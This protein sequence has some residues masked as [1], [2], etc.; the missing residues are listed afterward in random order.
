[1]TAYALPMTFHC[2]V[3][4]ER[5]RVRVAPAGELD[6]ATAP[7][8]EQAVQEL[9]DSGFAHVILDLTGVEFLDSGGLRMIL[10]LQA[11]SAGGRFRFELKPGSPAVQRIFELSATTDT[12]TFIRPLSRRTPRRRSP[13]GEAAQ[14][15]A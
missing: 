7:H 9:L 8:V 11:S 13:L 15:S 6:M 3:I 5:D 14:A 12:L 10:R 2:D 1:M 4:P